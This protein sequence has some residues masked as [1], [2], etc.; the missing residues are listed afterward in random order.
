MLGAV[1]RIGAT[2]NHGLNMEAQIQVLKRLTA[3]SSDPAP[4]H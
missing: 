4:H 2:S 3:L 1:M